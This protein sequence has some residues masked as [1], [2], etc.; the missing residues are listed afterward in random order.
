M[1]KYHLST[2]GNPRVC[3]AADGNCP[4]GGDAPHFSSKIAARAAFE[5]SVDVK[6]LASANKKSRRG[7]TIEIDP[8]LKRE[9]E[10]LE[11]VKPAPEYES[12]AAERSLD[13][14]KDGQQFYDTD[15]ELVEVVS[16]KT[17]SK[18]SNI[19][20]KNADGKERKIYRPKN[21][22]T[23]VIVR[24]ETEESKANSKIF[25]QEENLE[26]AIKRYEPRG[27][28]AAADL[29]VK[30]QAGYSADHWQYTTLME[31]NA[32]DF[33]HSDYERTV[34][35]VKRKIAEGHEDFKDEKT[36]YSRAYKV[37]ESEYTKEIVRAATRGES[38]SS[39]EV[40]NI[41][42][43]ILLG[44]KADFLDDIRWGF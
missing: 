17:G 9:V 4:L 22:I 1:A 20:A 10:E 28:K 21:E 7:E 27:A 14:L 26:R 15:G 40:S 44:A 32:K 37:L 11:T 34:D 23:K 24:A 41:T 5:A 19:V 30:I 3:T 16:I 35:I 6:I 39:S 12:Y 33:V 2:D 18:N 31:A 42:A 25:Y 36:P 38:N 43:R 13:S 29:M 8:I